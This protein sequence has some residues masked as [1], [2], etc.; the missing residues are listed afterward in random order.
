MLK[1]AVIG[2]ILAAASFCTPAAVCFQAAVKPDR[3]DSGLSWQQSGRALALAKQG[4]VIWRFS[5]ETEKGSTAAYFHPLRPVGGPEL[6]L[7]RPADHPWHTGLWFSWKY[8]NHLNYWD[9]QKAGVLEGITDVSEVRITPRDDFSAA[10]ESVLEY[11]PADKPS[12]MSERRLIAVTAPDRNGCFRID[13]TGGFTGGPE[14]LVLDRTPI[15]GEPDGKIYGGYAGF[16]VRMPENLRA[17]QFLDSGGGTKW[18]SLRDSGQRAKW[19]DF[20]CEGDKSVGGMAIFDHPENLRHP[21]PWWGG[22]YTGPMLLYYAPYTLAAGKSLT[23]KYRVLVHAG[24]L[25]VEAL[26][27]EWKTFASRK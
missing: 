1:R 17:L 12:V 5:V 22:A 24:R 18:G 27:R 13:W 19:L 7:Y 23:L 21:S 14:D 15:P 11:H 26:E 4:Q 10:I 8:I 25:D 16:G 3:G 9:G 6:T 2:L 20:S